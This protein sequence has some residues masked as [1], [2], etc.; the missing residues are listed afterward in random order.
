MHSFLSYTNHLKHYGKEIENMK[1]GLR[2]GHSPN[3]KGAVGYLDEQVE[4]RKI[5]NEL[6][7]ILKSAGHT[8]IDCNSNA[9]DVNS[10]LSEGTNKANSNGCDVYITIHMNASGGAGNGTECWLYNSSNATMNSIA[11]RVCDNFAKKGF[12][13]RGRKYNTG[14]H[15]LNASTMPA[16]IIETLFCDNSHD[17]GLYNSLGAKGIAQLIGAAIKGQTVSGGST[18]PSTPANS[19]NYS[20]STG[21]SGGA[22]VVFT[23]AVK[24][25]DGTILPA[26]SNLSD[27]AGLPGRT[28]AGIAIKANKGSVKY[29]VHVKGSG[30]YPYVTGYNWN[31]INNGWAGDNGIVIDAV[32]VYYYTPDDIVAKYGYQ[33]AQYRV[34]PIGGSYYPWQFDNETGNGQDGY[35]GVFGVAFDKFQLF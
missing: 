22:G 13:N 21:S 16:M 3:C 2:G 14:Y 24:L 19:G 11:D 7:P 30:W 25:T 4:V 35:A 27:Y 10:E 28:I 26:V 5:Y 6:V 12:Q 31:D 33:K 23:Y 8:V 15:D 17:V 20:S 34:A 29:R 32:E 9:Y 18:T 1:I